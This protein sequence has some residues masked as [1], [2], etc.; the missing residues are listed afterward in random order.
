[1]ALTPAGPSGKPAEPAVSPKPTEPD[2]TV[3]APRTYYGLS[4][5]QAD[6]PDVVVTQT[7]ADFV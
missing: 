6:K 4:L 3:D 5:T 2:G 1:M 7:K